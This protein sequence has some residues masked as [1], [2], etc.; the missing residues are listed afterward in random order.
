M[1]LET[2]KM[3]EKWTKDKRPPSQIFPRWTLICNRVCCRRWRENLGLE[4]II[5][6]EEDEE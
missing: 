6:K 3:I 2:E 1:K 5:P 4:R